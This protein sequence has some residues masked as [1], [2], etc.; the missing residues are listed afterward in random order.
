MSGKSQTIGNFTV[1]LT[2]PDFANYRR[3]PRSSGMDG[4]KFGESEAFPTRPRF[5]LWSAIIPDK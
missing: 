3:Y 4:D 1:L 5:L 2:V